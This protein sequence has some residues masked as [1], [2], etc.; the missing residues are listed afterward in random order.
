MKMHREKGTVAQRILELRLNRVTSPLVIIQKENSISA[1]KRKASSR[2]NHNSDF[3]LNTVVIDIGLKADSS[4]GEKH[5]N[6]HIEEKFRTRMMNPPLLPVLR[7]SYPTS[8]KI[9]IV[10]SRLTSSTPFLS[11][12]SL[13]MNALWHGNSMIVTAK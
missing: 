2:H 8:V 12:P 10:L 6:N 9:P 13:R 1:A 11:A 5:N 3:L 7:K 4:L